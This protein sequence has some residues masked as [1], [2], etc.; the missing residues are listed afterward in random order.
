[1]TRQ[2][3]ALIGQH[4]AAGELKE[5]ISLVGEDLAERPNDLSLH[6]RLRRLLIADGDASRLDELSERYLGLL[7]RSGNLDEAL[8]VLAEETERRAGWQLNE[9]GLVVPLAR[10]SLERGRFEQAGA[11]LRGFDKRWPGHADLPEVYLLGGRLIAEG[12]RD[13]SGARR[14]FEHVIAAYPG[15]A[16]AAQARRF[17]QVSEPAQPAPP[18]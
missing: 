16:A 13:A 12:A 5:A 9:A 8:Q 4:V 15:S 17:L 11:L 2:R 18:A 3:D 1:R 7:V 10:R 14:L 6:G